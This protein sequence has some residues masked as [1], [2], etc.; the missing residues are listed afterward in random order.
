[1]PSSPAPR[2]GDEGGVAWRLLD[3]AQLGDPVDTAGKLRRVTETVRDQ[4]Q[5]RRHT[6]IGG[7]SPAAPPA[8]HAAAAPPPEDLSRGHE[9]YQRFLSYLR[10]LR[11]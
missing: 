10:S 2:A 6:V 1:V 11:P 4:E 8:P 3:P 5:Q 7:P 9:D